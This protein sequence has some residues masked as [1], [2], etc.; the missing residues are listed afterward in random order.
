MIEA[1]ASHWATVRTS[2]RNNR[3]ER[4]PNAGSMLINVLKVRAGILVRATISKV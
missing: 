2:C 1:I 4:A 3:P